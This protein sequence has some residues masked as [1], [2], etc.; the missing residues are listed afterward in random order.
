MPLKVLVAP[1]KF[2]GTLTANAAAE[3]IAR[4]WRASRPDDDLELLPM[5]DDGDGFREIVSRLLRAERRTVRTVDAAHRPREASWG[6]AAPTRTAIVESAN[7]IGLALLPP[8]RF[9]PFELDTR[10]LGAVLQTARAHGARR[11]LVGIGGSATNDGGFGLAKALGWEFFD[12]QGKGLTHWTELHALSHVAPPSQSYLFDEL[13]VAVDVQNPLL[14]PNGCSRIYGP[15]KG[16]RPEDFEPAERCLARL[17]AQVAGQLGADVAREPGGG[18]AGGLG[19]GLRVFAGAT[20]E[21]GFKRFARLA[22]LEQ[23]LKRVQLVITGE[24]AIDP[25]SLMGKGVGELAQLCRRCG[26]PCLGLAGAISDAAQA[27]ET[28]VGVH[29][30]APDLTSPEDAKARP[31]FWLE[32]LAQQVGQAWTG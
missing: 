5:S 30:L 3:A 6:W 4:G 1:D 23:R 20:L 16:L 22:E 18:A 31:A 9:H 19:F 13:V 27:R 11:C 25:S 8:G 2:K 24:G 29:A 32:R 12:A 14:G 15:Q 26:V 28:F 21:P 10:G 17:A 7:V